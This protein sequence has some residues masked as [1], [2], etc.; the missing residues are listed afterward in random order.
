MEAVVDEVLGH[1]PGR[2]RLRGWIHR[3]ALI[4]FPLLGLAVVLDAP[5]WE[6]RWPTIVFVVGM[7]G[8]FA[9]S[10]TFHLGAWTGPRY[11]L[12]RRLDHSMNFVAIASGYTPY[13]AICFAG[14]VR[15]E[16][17]VGYWVLI[18]LAIGSRVMWIHAPA[19]VVAGSYLAL[20]W[21][22]IVLLPFVARRISLTDLA[23]VF[24]AAGCF[25]VGAVI[26]ARERPD[27]WPATF[28]YHELFHALALAGQLVLLVAVWLLFP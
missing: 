24:L 27:P 9:V 7:T 19:K 28:G 8:V 11:T 4:G 26:Y 6:Y 25:S 10:S 15:T 20:G 18:T 5:G 13:L 16:L 1:E 21:V 17:L 14:V 3:V 2:P 23:L 22:G 12:M